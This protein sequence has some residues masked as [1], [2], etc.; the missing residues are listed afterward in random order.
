MASKIM[1][2]APILSLLFIRNLEKSEGIIRSVF[3]LEKGI[4]T[5][6]MKESGKQATDKAKS[7]LDPDK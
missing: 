4:I 2:Q 7:L 6:G 3:R 5:S 1:N